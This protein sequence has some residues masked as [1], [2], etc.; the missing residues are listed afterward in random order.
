M[1][2]GVYQCKSLKERFWEKVIVKGPDVCWE[3]K[4]GCNNYGYGAFWSFHNKVEG[5]H[6]VSWKLHNGPIPRGMCVLHHCDNP[7]CVNPAHLFLGTKADNT[8][9]MMLKGRQP[10]ISMIR[11]PG[12]SNGR[13]KLT[14]K[15]VRIIRG[16]LYSGSILAREYGVSQSQICRIIKGNTWRCL[17]DYRYKKKEECA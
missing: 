13:A 8:K 1:P 6:R 11:H 9:D 17:D 16:K 7:L 12:E 10:A 4:G 3:W 14:E 5:A 15:E 2:L